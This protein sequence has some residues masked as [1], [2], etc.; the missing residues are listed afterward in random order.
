M[1]R[2][3]DILLDRGF[4]VELGMPYQ[5]NAD[6]YPGLKRVFID[7]FFFQ[8]RHAWKSI[9]QRPGSIF[10]STINVLRLLG[11]R[12]YAAVIAVDPEALSSGLC[13][14][15]RNTPRVYLS[16]EILFQ[17]ESDDWKFKERELRG[18]KLVRLALCQDELRKA[19][20]AEQS[21]IPLERIRTVPVAPSMQSH[22]HQIDFLRR[23]LNIPKNRKILL[24]SGNIQE[25][26]IQKSAREIASVLPEHFCW[27]IHSSF[28]IDKNWKQQLA[29]F[30]V[31]GRVYFY[32]QKLEREAY[33]EMVASADVGFAPYHPTYSSWMT[34]K[35]LFHIGDA[36]GKFAAFSLC[37]LPIL[38]S[39]LPTFA[40]RLK[41]YS[42][43]AV[44]DRIEQIPSLVQD[45]EKN[46]A[47]YSTESFRYFRETLNSGQ[48]ESFAEEVI[49]LCEMSTD[50]S[51]LVQRT[52]L[53]QN[54]PRP[55]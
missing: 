46:H 18:A 7:R 48:L 39:A 25:W 52:L 49:Q 5:G 51:H 53:S 34:G 17:D 42:F 12:N 26:S 14:A 22:P 10:R 47:F 35:N 44:F 27:V 32:P 45:I 40:Q 50:P 6:T 54:D 8:R 24:Y 3:V 15:L 28:K 23:K 1:A 19:H 20:L 13:H 36:S 55:A 41:E 9:L 16:F 43:G 33:L 21:G 30:V 11:C 37:R 4:Q 29:E 38:A 31:Q 2:L